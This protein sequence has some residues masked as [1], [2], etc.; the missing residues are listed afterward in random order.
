MEELSEPECLRLVSQEV[1]GRLAY[2]GRYGLTVL[3]VNYRLVDGVVLFR[4]A[5][6]S[7]TGLDLRTGIM[8]AEQRVSFEVDSRHRGDREGLER[9]YP[10]TR[11]CPRNPGRAGRRAGGGDMGMARRQ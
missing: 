9:P 6:D 11:S 7:L 4:I 2:T 10:G 1:I 3:A 8:N 5:E